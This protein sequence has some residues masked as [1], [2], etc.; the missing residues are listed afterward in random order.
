[1]T[2]FPVLQSTLI[3]AS[4][5]LFLFVGLIN[6]VLY[7]RGQGEIALST[8]KEN[9]WPYMIG[10]SVILP[11]YMNLDTYLKKYFFGS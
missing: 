4:W 2:A 11:W 6:C 1:M 10:L 8:F 3:N 7:K 9:V 5:K